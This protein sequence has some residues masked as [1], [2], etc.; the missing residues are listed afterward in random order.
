MLCLLAIDILFTIFLH[1]HLLQS[2]GGHRTIAL[3]FLRAM[4]K[5]GVVESNFSAFRYPVFVYLDIMNS[6]F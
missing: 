1:G 2:V 4:V 6:R 5:L 3:S